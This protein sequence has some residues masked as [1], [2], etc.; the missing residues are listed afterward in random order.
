MDIRSVIIFIVVAVLIYL[1]TTRDRFMP[2]GPT[3]RDCA[4]VPEYW[5]AK[6]CEDPIEDRNCLI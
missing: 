6:E 5:S 4:M 3:K 1:G 2:Y